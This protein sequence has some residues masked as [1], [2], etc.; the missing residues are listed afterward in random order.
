MGAMTKHDLSDAIQ[1]LTALADTLDAFTHGPD[2]A[3]V[4]ISGV[5]TKTILHLVRDF[6]MVLDAKVSWADSTLLEIVLRAE[7]AAQAADQAARQGEGFAEYVI[8]VTETDGRVRVVLDDLNHPEMGSLFNPIINVLA[9]ELCTYVLVDRTK[10][11]F[12]VQLY[13]GDGT[14]GANAPEFIQ[15]A[16]D[17]ELGDDV[18]L[19]RE[20]GEVFVHLLVSI[21]NPAASA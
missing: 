12:T 18:E 10:E 16:E 15:C 8:P 17:L 19:G 21:P 13:R 4:D 7:A 2:N 6:L 3:Y 11:Y 1:R 9:P 5:P 14:P 20:A